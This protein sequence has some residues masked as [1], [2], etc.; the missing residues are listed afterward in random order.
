MSLIFNA[1]KKWHT[2][3]LRKRLQ[4]YGLQ[5]HVSASLPPELRFI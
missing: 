3:W 2:F 5:Y 4:Q 1:L